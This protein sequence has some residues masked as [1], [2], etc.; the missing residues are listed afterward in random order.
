VIVLR[1]SIGDYDTSSIIEGSKDFKIMAWILWMLIL[2]IGNVVFMNFIIAVVSE[3]YENCM[4]KKIQLIY[5]AKLEMIKE[6]EDLLPEW[7]FLKKN[8][9]PTFIII[10]REQGSSSGQDQSDEWYG[11]VKQM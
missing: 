6:C 9:F 2:I 4:E 11:F 10:R 7:V 8:W 1:Q 5:K 3:S